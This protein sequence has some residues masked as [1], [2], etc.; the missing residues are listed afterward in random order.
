MKFGS[1]LFRAILGTGVGLVI[2]IIL[3]NQI[4]IQDFQK[5]FKNISVF[6]IFA[7]F[8]LYTLSTLLRAYRW[9]KMLLSKSVALPTLFYVTS[10]HNLLN[11]L[12]PARTGEISYVMLLRK[13]QSIPASEG[14]A[15][16]IL[17]RVIDLL[18]MGV[19]FLGSIIFYWGTIR[20]PALK[21]FLITFFALPLLMV[22]F[23]GLFSRKG[24][25]IICNGFSKF[26]L[27]KWKIFSK[28]ADFLTRLAQDLY[29]IK[30]SKQL[31]SYA[32]F[33]LLAW[34]AKFFAFYCVAQNLIFSEPITFGET[35]L[36]TTFSELASTLP[37]YGVAGLG[38][39]EGGWTLGFLLLGFPK[40]EV[41]LSA[42][43]FHF[44]L[45]TFSSVLGVTSF[46]LLKKR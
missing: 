6:W 37:I 26:G 25:Q 8:S 33:T 39:I 36:G 10:I 24:V 17:A 14:V 23:I 16:L 31:F 22:I 9:K 29:Q 34:G 15:T 40:N 4:Q 20:V 19:F 35:V 3:F 32:F 43:C 2:A 46:F 30:M 1:S 18:A 27:M 11:H 7:A 42:F 12:L 13:T 41:I 44:F 45:L 5:V 28:I 38:T 21:L